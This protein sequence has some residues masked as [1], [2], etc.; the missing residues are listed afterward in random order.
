V[1]EDND[2]FSVHMLS[3][4][5]VAARRMIRRRSPHGALAICAIVTVV[6]LH[7]ESARLTLV[8]ELYGRVLRIT[9]TAAIG[10]GA[11]LHWTV[12]HTE[13]QSLTLEGEAALVTGR[14]LAI[15]NTGGWPAGPVLVLVETTGGGSPN[16]VVTGSVA[17]PAAEQPPAP[18]AAFPSELS[19]IAADQ[20][21]SGVKDSQETQRDNAQPIGPDRIVLAPGTDFTVRLIDPIPLR[22]H[23]AVLYRASLDEDVYAGPSVVIPHGAD[24][25]LQ[26]VNTT[27]KD[28]AMKTGITV[29]AVAVRV[30]GQLMDVAADDSTRSRGA[31]GH[32]A[33]TSIPKRIAKVAKSVAI[34]TISGLVGGAVFGAPQI[35]VV[36]GLGV[37]LTREVLFARSSKKT[38][39]SETRVSLRLVAPLVLASHAA[40]SNRA[41]VPA[42][43]LSPTLRERLNN[44]E[45]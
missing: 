3:L 35:G 45:H 42:G 12:H 6:M 41:E 32:Q 30:N 27:R 36:V 39:P 38:L 13:N 20:A 4:V 15:I 28:S 7:A 24:V 34:P 37:G 18:L 11:S 26:L 33:S 44:D 21:P 5:N 10:N 23:A 22:S 8:P 25:L 17:L 31:A 1:K 29:S 2:M 16:E 43:S 14:Y 40:A 19:P 9:G